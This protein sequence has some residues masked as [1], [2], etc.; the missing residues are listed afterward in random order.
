M[1]Y[2]TMI[3]LDTEA[4][5][6]LRQFRLENHVKMSDIIQS[7]VNVSNTELKGVRS[8]K[9]ILSDAQHDM[10]A[11]RNKIVLRFN[12]TITDKLNSI[13]LEN[14]SS[15]SEIVRCLIKQTDFSK[16]QFEDKCIPGKMSV[17]LDSDVYRK[18]KE[19]S[20]KNFISQTEIVSTLIKTS[21]I[22][23]SPVEGV[24][25]DKKVS[26]N[27]RGL[28]QIYLDEESFSKLKKMRVENS[29][30][31][32][33]II[34]NL[35]K[36]AILEVYHFKSKAMMYKK[37]NYEIKYTSVGLNNDIYSKIREYSNKNKVSMS[38]ILRVLVGRSDV[39]LK[40]NP[41]K[42]VR[43][44]SKKNKN[45]VHASVLFYLNQKLLD[46]LAL[47]RL[48]ND[49]SF[50][51]IINILV[52]EADFKKMKFRTIKEVHKSGHTLK[53]W[54]EKWNKIKK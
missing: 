43:L 10:T 20:V 30:S 37:G 35:I 48:K 26:G 54:G 42:Y 41:K 11:G 18:L 50:S 49:A 15:L 27:K 45:T 22:K 2:K 16:L 44:Y 47:M 38:K 31:N 24:S 17:R 46:K 4:F 52:D 6:K 36:M 8:L 14:N 13:K 51:E 53:K 25:S 7:L 3:R 29:M 40:T 5:D 9:N 34:S 21:S 12:K 32:S 28:I 23:I 1:D 39:L 19:F 33:K